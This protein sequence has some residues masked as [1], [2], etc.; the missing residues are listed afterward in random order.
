MGIVSFGRVT[1]IDPVQPD[2]DSP[3]FPPLQLLCPTTMSSD[4]IQTAKALGIERWIDE[5]WQ[6]APMSLHSS[7][8]A[9]IAKLSAGGLR[10]TQ[11][12]WPRRLS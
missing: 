3:L 10:S 5:E 11:A 1:W 6:V 2:S 9:D 8:D 7:I 12:R 4:H